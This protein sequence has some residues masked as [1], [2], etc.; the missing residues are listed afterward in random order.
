MRSWHS[1]ASDVRIDGAINQQIVEFIDYHGAKSVS[2][3]DGI[4]G[5]PHQEGVDYQGDWCPA[6]DFWKGRDRFTGKLLS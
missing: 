4:I 3:V 6:C 2:M 5:C 1:D